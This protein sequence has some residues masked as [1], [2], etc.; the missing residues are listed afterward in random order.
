M[1][2]IFEIVRRAFGQ[3]FM[4]VALLAA[5]AFVACE[6]EGIKIDVE[7]N[8]YK[9]LYFTD[10]EDGVAKISCNGNSQ[11]ISLAFNV[12][13]TYTISTDGSEW[14]TIVSGETGLAGNQRAVKLQVSDNVGEDVREATVSITVGDAEPCTIAIITQ[15]IKTL[16]PIVE[17]V[18]ERLSEEYYWLDKYNELRTAGKIDY[19]LQGST[20]LYDALTGKKWENVN[21]DDGYMGSD[22]KWHLFSYLAM[23]SSGTKASSSDMVSGF[24]VELCYTVISFQN[25]P[26]YAF[27]VEH[28]YPDSPAYV[29]GLRRGDMI[30][31]VNDVQI[32]N[33]NYQTLHTTIQNSMGGSITLSTRAADGVGM[34]DYTISAGVYHASP[35]AYSGLLTENAE[36][37]FDFGG[38]K[39]G[40][41]SYL[42]FDN[43]YDQELIAAVQALYDGGATDIIVDLRT[44]TGGAVYSSAY[45]ASMLL[46]ESYAG[47]E[48]VTL[49]RHKDNKEGDSVVPFFASVKLGDV[50]NPVEVKLP[51]FDNLKKV[52]F[53]TSDNTASAS[54]MLIMGLRAQG[55]EA[56]T[57][58]TQSMGKDC[59]MDVMQV[60]YMSQL[61][62]FAPITFMNVFPDYDVDFSDGIPADIDFV[63]I[64]E[65]VNDKDM[66]QALSWYPLPEVGADWADYAA[67]IALGEAVAN[68][69]GGTIFDTPSAQGRVLAMPKVTTRSAQS[70][71][72][73]AVTMPKPAIKGMYVY[74][75]KIVEIE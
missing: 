47:K 50:T 33:L 64:A 56:V 35:I 11:S 31:K 30:M 41:I 14:L 63:K 74:S 58:G 70:R 29:A 19:S 57:V 10:V 7:E 26:N 5:V 65:Q 42:S 61:Y 3:R 53:I 52:Y 72:T 43:V 34:E 32:D 60:R 62:E 15:A 12:A 67:D 40:Y 71:G 9:I 18:D 16:D 73:K 4:L 51:H 55:I 17:W 21:K 44:N 46:P 49:K 24:G 69:L 39:I 25:S 36:L 68:I 1:E 45:F 8:G 2:R 22:G 23:L 59:G 75:D 28:V 13:D 37:D 27:L 48:M 6:D 38:K 66:R 20:F 54:E